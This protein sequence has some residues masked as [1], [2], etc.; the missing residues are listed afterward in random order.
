M[1]KTQRICLK[2]LGGQDWNTLSSCDSKCL[3]NRRNIKKKSVF[4]SYLICDVGPH[5]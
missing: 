3:D 5:K 2:V 1:Y 4:F